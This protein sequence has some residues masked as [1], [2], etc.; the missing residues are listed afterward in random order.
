MNS[1]DSD[2][3]KNKDK[4]E[5]VDRLIKPVIIQYF[6]IIRVKNSKME[7]LLQKETQKISQFPIEEHH[8]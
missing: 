7:L 1:T 2:L 4:S 3:K 6:F 8:I 5:E